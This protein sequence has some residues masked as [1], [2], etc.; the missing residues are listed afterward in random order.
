MQ[1]VRLNVICIV[2]A[3]TICMAAKLKIASLYCYYFVDFASQP[4]DCTQNQ[5]LLSVLYSILGTQAGRPR[6]PEE[7]A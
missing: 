2:K 7:Y 5:K 3:K 4:F 1:L 6:E